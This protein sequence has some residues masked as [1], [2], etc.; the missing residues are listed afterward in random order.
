MND[1]ILPL[2]ECCECGENTFEPTHFE[3]D[4][5]I[6]KSL[7][8]FEASFEEDELSDGAVASA[9]RWENGASAI[10]HFCGES[11]TIELDGDRANTKLSDMEVTGVRDC[12]DFD[13]EE[14][15][16][17]DGPGELDF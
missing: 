11:L 16:D 8:D 3:H 1:E 9:C 12:I 7:S 10:C 15:E 14:E 2:L 6:Y 13:D 17:S 4:D 5:V